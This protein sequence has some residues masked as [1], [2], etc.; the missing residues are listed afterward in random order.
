MTLPRVGLEIRVPHRIALGAVLDR[1]S[2]AVEGCRNPEPLLPIVGGNR[3]V[4]GPTVNIGTLA[5]VLEK[6]ATELVARAL[7]A[8]EKP[9]PE[10][11]VRVGAYVHAQVV[12]ALSSDRLDGAG[13]EAVAD[14]E[15]DS[16]VKR[17]GRRSAAICAPTVHGERPLCYHRL[18]RSGRRCRW[19]RWC[20]VPLVPL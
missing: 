8:K 4:A 7:D 20:P 3:A 6:N 14:L 10:L 18:H 17:V 12:R 11:G 5:S 9:L 19:C 1:E 16:W 15:H 13:V 2:R